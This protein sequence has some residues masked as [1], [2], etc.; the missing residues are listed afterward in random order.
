[1]RIKQAPLFTVLEMMSAKS[2]IQIQPAPGLPNPPIE[3]NYAGLT[4]MEMLQDLGRRYSF[5][6]EDQHD[7]SIWVIPAVDS[8]AGLPGSGSKTGGAVPAT[9]AGMKDR[10]LGG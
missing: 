2:G 10:K 1:M 7:G 3:V 5:T 9:T 6:P 4:A 8:A